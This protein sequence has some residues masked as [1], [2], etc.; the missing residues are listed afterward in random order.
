MLRR[1]APPVLSQTSGGV[2]PMRRGAART[3]GS[4]VRPRCLAGAGH[5]PFRGSACSSSCTRRC[6]VACRVNY[7][8][9]ERNTPRD[10]VRCSFPPYL[11][12]AVECH[13]AQRK[14]P[15][16]PHWH[17]VAARETMTERQLRHLSKR[18]PCP[19]CDLILEASVGQGRQL[20]VSHNAHALCADCHSCRPPKAAAA[21][22]PSFCAD[23][24]WASL[25]AIP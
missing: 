22:S 9:P 11:P 14:V 24:S 4:P 16:A 1:H 19:R 7:G 12:L 20:K 18:R 15:R 8:E 3:S 17:V 10:V 6:A 2:R 25:E 13:Y 5:L 23:Q 21:A